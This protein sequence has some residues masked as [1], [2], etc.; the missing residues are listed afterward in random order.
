MQ[1]NSWMTAIRLLWRKGHHW[2]AIATWFVMQWVFVEAYV[3]PKH[4]MRRAI[5]EIEKA[6]R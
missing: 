6:K 5:R 3:L 1:P 4:S 2:E